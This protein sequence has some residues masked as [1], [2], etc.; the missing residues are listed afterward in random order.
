MI[1]RQQLN[2]VYSGRGLPESNN[3]FIL[4]VFG[5]FGCFK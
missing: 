4:S 5:G 1:Y 2:M 3:I